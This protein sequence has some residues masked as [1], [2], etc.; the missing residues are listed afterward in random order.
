M[1]DHLLWHP[2]IC[3]MPSGHP[4]FCA[5]GHLGFWTSGHLGFW[6]SGLLGIMASG[7]LGFCTSIQ[8]HPLVHEHDSLHEHELPK[9]SRS[10]SIKENQD[11][12][13][14]SIAIEISDDNSKSE[15]EQE[16]NPQI[17]EMIDELNNDY[18]N[19]IVQDLEQH[20]DENTTT[21]VTPPLRDSPIDPEIEKS[22]K[23]A[24]RR[25]LNKVNSKPKF[26][27]FKPRIRNPESLSHSKEDE[28]P[29]IEE[30]EQKLASSLKS[31]NTSTSE[32]PIYYPGKDHSNYSS[33]SNNKSIINLGPSKYRSKIIQQA[34]APKI[35]TTSVLTDLLEE[36]NPKYKT[37]VSKNTVKKS[38]P[39]MFSLKL[40]GDMGEQVQRESNVHTFFSSNSEESEEKIKISKEEQGEIAKKEQKKNAR[41]QREEER[42][43]RRKLN[44][45]EK[46]ERE[47]KEKEQQQEKKEKEEEPKYVSSWT[48]LNSDANIQPKLPK[49]NVQNTMFNTFQANA[50]TRMIPLQ[51]WQ[52]PQISPQPSLSIPSWHQ[53]QK[54]VSSKSSKKSSEKAFEKVVEKEKDK[55]TT[56][57]STSSAPLGSTW[58]LLTD[59]D[60]IQCCWCQ[61]LISND[62]STT[63]R[64]THENYHMKKIYDGNLPNFLKKIVDKKLMSYDNLQSNSVQSEQSSSRFQPSNLDLIKN[65][66]LV[67]YREE[68]GFFSKNFS[69]LQKH[70]KN[71]HESDHRIL[72]KKCPK[73][74]LRQDQYEGHLVCS[75]EI[76][77]TTRGIFST[78]GASGKSNKEIDAALKNYIK[79]KISMDENFCRYI[80]KVSNQANNLL[81]GPSNN[82][83]QGWGSNNGHN[84]I[85]REMKD[86][87]IDMIESE[88]IKAPKEYYKMVANKKKRSNERSDRHDPKK[89]SDQDSEEDRDEI[90]ERPIFTRASDTAPGYIRNCPRIKTSS[91]CKDLSTRNT[92]RYSTYNYR[93]RDRN[94]ERDRDRK[95]EKGQRYEEFPNTY[96]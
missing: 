68:C 48:M 47:R 40:P 73:K 44:K 42:K 78:S 15:Q 83:K 38:L 72:C 93:D 30:K 90:M 77:S 62:N 54:V 66:W 20:K 63:C 71:K 49:V 87:V 53:P 96:I 50:A 24:Q 61:D 70:V 31:P 37:S 28:E 17:Q 22:K 60:Q 51:H 11:P 85:A 89:S 26:S 9:F 55:P 29:S 46:K 4:G 86:H 64:C 36:D 56:P 69:E 39:P 35:P 1:S 3:Q 5:S 27:K 33:H 21:V 25:I 18:D 84:E 45:K 79:D 6:A 94:K 19:Q 7:H 12:C 14:N 58:H 91:S 23:L 65:Y 57:N 34:S 80:L 10:K 43:L 32:K 92:G 41:E 75:S 88:K 81:H 8:D 2:G 82:R 59:Q 95:Q 67:C 13:E 74:F 16:T 76:F 52:P